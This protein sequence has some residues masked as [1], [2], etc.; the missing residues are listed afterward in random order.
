M[1]KSNAVSRVYLI[2]RGAA[3]MAVMIVGALY[4]SDVV[5]GR[6]YVGIAVLGLGILM[7]AWGVFS[8]GESRRLVPFALASAMSTAG[9]SLVDGLGARVMGDAVSYVAWLFIYDALVF[10]PV[11]M[12]LKGTAVLRASPRVWIYASFAAAGFYGAYA[13]AVWAMT[14]APIALVTALCEAS[15]L[16]AVLLGWVL[17]KE[18]MTRGKVMAVVMIVAGVILMQI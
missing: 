10:T 5:T 17:F 11:S 3:L 6:E 15:I 14:V 4:L 9:Y 16:F 7:M 12:M 2:A 18:R 1:V 8:G 13:I